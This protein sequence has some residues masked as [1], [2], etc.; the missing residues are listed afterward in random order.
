MSKNR[1]YT[2]EFKREVVAEYLAGNLNLHELARKHLVSRKL[3]RIWAEKHEAG[4]L[5]EE[6]LASEL[7]AERDA[8]IEVL[9]RLVGRQ[10]LE[11][12]FLK[13]ALKSTASLKGGRTSVITGP[14]PSPSRKDVD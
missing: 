11:I 8:K 1:R 2:I 9:E 5:D 4:E 3:I 14:L 6:A 13:G 12:D 7:L 10:A